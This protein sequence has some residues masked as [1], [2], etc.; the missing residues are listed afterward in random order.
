M[1]CLVHLALV[2]GCTRYVVDQGY[3]RGVKAGSSVIS[4]L[5]PDVRVATAFGVIPR[6]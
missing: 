6:W 3:A 1:A 2:C 4:D 5:E